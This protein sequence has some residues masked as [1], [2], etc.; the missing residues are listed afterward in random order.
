MDWF[1]LLTYGGG[2]LKPLH[3]P[4]REGSHGVGVWQVCS[5]EVRVLQGA[6]RLVQTLTLAELLPDD[7][8]VQRHVAA[9]MLPP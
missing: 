9:C 7:A 1:W 8:E 2:G 5:T 6:R 4:V 3:V